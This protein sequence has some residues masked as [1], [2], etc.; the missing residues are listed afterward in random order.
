MSKSFEARLFTNM[1]YCPVWIDA[2]QAIAYVDKAS[3]SIWGFGYKEFIRAGVGAFASRNG[4][5]TVPRRAFSDAG[6][7]AL[8]ISLCG[9]PHCHIERLRAQGANPRRE[10]GGPRHGRHHLYWRWARVLCSDGRLRRRLRPIVR[11]RNMTEPIIGL[12]VGIS[13]GAYLLYTLIYPEKF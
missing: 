2:S 8:M 5:K 11:S 4:D 10:T 6:F 13:L 12:I 7:P 3:I 9:A 1:A